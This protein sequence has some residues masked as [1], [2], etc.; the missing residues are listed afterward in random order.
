M[1]RGAED[2]PEGMDS[3]GDICADYLATLPTHET[4]QRLGWAD[5]VRSHSERTGEDLPFAAWLVH[6]AFAEYPSTTTRHTGGREFR[7][8]VNEPVQDAFGYKL[9]RRDIAQ[10]LDWLAARRMLP[11]WTQRAQGKA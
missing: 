2:L 7:A 9:S 8:L 1:N 6:R 3:I 4:A 11:P 10:G 5:Y